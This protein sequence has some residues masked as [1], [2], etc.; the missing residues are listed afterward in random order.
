VEAVAGV[1][2]VEGVC[3]WAGANPAAKNARSRAGTV[4]KRC[5]STVRLHEQGRDQL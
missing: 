3:A 4:T 2:G 5:R 1:E